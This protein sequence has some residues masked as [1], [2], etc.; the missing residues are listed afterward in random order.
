MSVSADII[1]YSTFHDWIIEGIIVGKDSLELRI[2]S[3]NNETKSLQF[4]NRPRFVITNVLRQ[5]VIL[6]YVVLDDALHDPELIQQKR[7]VLDS[8]FPFA[9]GE[10]R[11]LA[12]IE[13]SIGADGY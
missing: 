11:H 3:E 7:D 6:R 1:E 4:G 10:L 2:R 12:F 9:K 5:N 8:A 13:A